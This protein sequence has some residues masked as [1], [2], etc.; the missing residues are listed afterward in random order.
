MN[1]Q[2]ADEKFRKTGILEK[3][4]EWIA[5]GAEKQASGKTAC[6]T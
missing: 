5:Q 1:E 6:L 2:N 3:L 4:L